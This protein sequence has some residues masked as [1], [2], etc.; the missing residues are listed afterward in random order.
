MAEVGQSNP[1]TIL[2][3]KK[4]IAD[5]VASALKDLDGVRLA[6]KTFLDQLLEP[7]TNQDV[8]QVVIRAND[9]NQISLDIKVCVRYGLPISD[10]AKEIQSVVRTALEKNVAINLKEINVSIQGL[11]RTST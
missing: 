9:Q 1:G 3:Q 5:I 10:V 8:P 2:I 7:F 11:E 6:D 4:V